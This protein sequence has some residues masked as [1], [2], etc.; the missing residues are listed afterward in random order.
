M[1]SG[2]GA[3]HQGLPQTERLASQ[4]G[5]QRRGG[6]Q[7]CRSAAN[8]SRFPDVKHADQGAA[9][10]LETRSIPSPALALAG[11]YLPMMPKRLTV[12]LELAAW[13][14]ESQRTL[15]GRR[16]QGSL[17][18]HCLATGATGPEGAL[19]CE[20]GVFTANSLRRIASRLPDRRVFGFDS[21]V[22][23]QEDWELPGGTVSK[24]FFHIEGSAWLDVGDNVE[25]VKGF[26]SE[27]LP[28]FLAANPEPFG[29][30][31]IDCDLY[32]STR[33]IFDLA[34]SRFQPGTVVVFDEFFCHGAD[35]R[36]EFT[37]FY[38]WTRR[39]GRRFEF[40]GVGDGSHELM[41]RIPKL[42][43][44]QFMDRL[45]AAIVFRGVKLLRGKA[46]FATS[47]AVKIL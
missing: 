22:G 30:V 29:F 2:R 41:T 21:F 12:D 14:E 35:N 38:E 18:D 47:V 36:G 43:E 28:A 11:G 19:V 15:E 37:A 27:S 10:A 24:D 1:Q 42:G 40:I 44:P 23:F 31:H 32:T 34:G 3:S 7:R 9:D 25:L 33:D 17:L 8:L 45:G 13:L 46:D 4:L 6:A 5:A 20:F 16:V 26:F 39:T